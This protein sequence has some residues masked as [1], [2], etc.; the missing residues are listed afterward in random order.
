ME[1]LHFYC[2]FNYQTIRNEMKTEKTNTQKTFLDI[3]RVNPNRKY[4]ILNN[5]ICTVI[6]T[7]NTFVY[8]IQATLAIVGP[9]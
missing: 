3:E 6:K 5:A 1:L 2:H 4:I 7:T 9:H 8:T